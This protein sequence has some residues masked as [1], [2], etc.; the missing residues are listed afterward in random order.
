[1][2]VRVIVHNCGTQ[3]KTTLLMIFPLILQ[4][5]IIVQTGGEGVF[6]EF[7]PSVGD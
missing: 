7:V 3:H 4:T 5:I 2:C 1:M 6:L